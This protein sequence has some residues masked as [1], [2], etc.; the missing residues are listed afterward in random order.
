MF[1]ILVTKGTFFLHITA[2]II[3]IVLLLLLIIII[4]AS[5]S[6]SNVLHNVCPHV[7]FGSTMIGKTTILF[8][9]VMA[10][11]CCQ[12]YFAAPR[13]HITGSGS[14]T[15]G[16][17]HTLTCTV[18]LPTGVAVTPDVRWEGSGLPGDPTG[19]VVVPT[20]ETISQP[21]LSLPWRGLYMYTATYSV[22]GQ[23]SPEGEIYP[24]CYCHK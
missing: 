18:T 10:V 3:I 13:V 20:Q 23:S 1:F 15:V 2:C 4:K 11:V 7:I 17:S 8:C 9:V 21:S 24:Q 14:A 6:S 16:S 22:D 5:I 12:P 19:T